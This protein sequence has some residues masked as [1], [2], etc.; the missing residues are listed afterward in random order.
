M[1]ERGG[2]TYRCVTIQL[3][4]EVLGEDETV[5]ETPPTEEEL[6][7]TVD[8]LLCHGTPMEALNTALFQVGCQVAEHQTRAG[9]FANWLKEIAKA[10]EDREQTNDQDI[11]I[12]NSGS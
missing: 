9:N 12:P 2:K 7:N 1:I 4:I 11:P 3:A 6:A 10:V 5:L 8:S